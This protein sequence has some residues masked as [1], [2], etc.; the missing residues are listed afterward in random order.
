M[1]D[2]FRPIASIRNRSHSPSSPQSWVVVAFVYSLD[3]TPQ[4][5]EMQII[6]N[7]QEVRGRCRAIPDAVDARRELINTY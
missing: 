3:T 2:S 4:K 7:H 6:R 1:I 5:P